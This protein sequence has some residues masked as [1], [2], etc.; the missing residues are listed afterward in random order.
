LGLATTAQFLQTF[1]EFPPSQRADSWSIDKLTERFL[2]QPQ[3][4]R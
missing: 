3:E 4:A 1:Q 2:Q